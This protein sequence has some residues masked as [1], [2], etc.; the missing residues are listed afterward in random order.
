MLDCTIAYGLTFLFPESDDAVG[1]SLRSHGEFARAEVDFLLAMAQG[2]GTLID[3]GA[4]VGSIGLP[5]AAKR[6]D[7]RVVAVEAHRGLS[8]V[9]HANALNN[10]LYNV[11]VLHA[12]AG[13]VRGYIEFPA[14][15]LSERRNF[16]GISADM[17]DVV[18]E[19]V[20]MAPLSE[21][22]PPDT[23]LIKIDVEGAEP[24]VLAGAKAL[25]QSRSIVWLV[26]AISL[27]PAASAAVIRTFQE[28]GY[29]TYWFFAPFVTPNAPKGPPSQAGRGDANVVALPPGSPNLW[30]L[31][32]VR[33]P[34]ETVPK[35]AGAFPYLSAYGFS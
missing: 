7:W 14:F 12:A 26:E 27:R 22:A 34:D 3:V 32:P 17:P 8:G 20:P 24:N 25:I 21:I 23:K 13:D 15:P 31:T 5:F 18:K 1:A 19:L 2:V 10:R 16:G 9:L 6:P 30:N 4:N 33:S 28:A 11:D 35:R 29:D